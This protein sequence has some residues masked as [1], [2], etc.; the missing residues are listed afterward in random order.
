[1]KISNDFKEKLRVILF[2]IIPVIYAVITILI[3]FLS[4]KSFMQRVDP[5][6][7]HLFNGI[8]IAIGNLAV[9]Y[10]AHPGTTI[11]IIYALSAH[12]VNI[13]LPGSGIVS[14]VLD[15]PEVFIHAAII[16]M[17][18]ITATA[19]LSLGYYTYKFTNNLFAAILLQLLVFGNYHLVI[20]SARIIPETVL[21]APIILLLIIIIKFLNDENRLSNTK[22]YL[23]SFAIIGGLGMA[24]KFSYLPFLIPPF[25]LFHDWKNRFKYLLF[26]VIATLIIAFPLV[27]NYSKSWDW[28][29]SMLLHSGRWGSGEN[30][31]IDFNAFPK[32]IIN[33][34]KYDKVLSTVTLLAAIQFLV[35]VTLK[36]FKIIRFNYLIARS[37]LSFIVVYAIA[38]LLVAKH[39]AYHY[40]SPF[41]VIKMILIYLMTI[42][43]LELFQ[44]EKTKKYI[45][46]LSLIIGLLLVYFQL[47]PLQIGVDR[48]YQIAKEN[49]ERYETMK[50]YFN[51][52]N[53]LIISSHYRGSPF[54]QSAFVST[55]LIN[56]FLKSTFTEELMM[57]YP[58]SYFSLNWTDDF[59][60][61]DDFL[62]AGDFI[63]PEK[64][65]LIF[66][67]KGLENDLSRV[68]SRIEEQFPDYNQELTLLVKFETPDEYLYELKLE[69]IKSIIPKE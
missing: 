37:L 50:P 14:K 45:S 1:M 60:L 35:F 18:I 48:K 58:K 68:L 16:L 2:A 36:Y 13:F 26:T 53:T 61:W 64:K 47:N 22:F 42:L 39:F 21:L 38:V 27:V 34:I 15:N 10:I 62:N 28:F 41:F 66:I 12:I 9:E 20:I 32:N 19:L 25:F 44:G 65:I 23:I 31:I 43:F 63:N 6:Y 67:G 57:R 46:A 8:N 4:G 56:G 29:S 24:G 3:H 54:I 11:Q 59:Y 7:L 30:T 49:D 55:F 52:E 51:N 40:F 33:L 5:E 17:N 69:K